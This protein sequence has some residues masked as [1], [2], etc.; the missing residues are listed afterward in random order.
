MSEKSQ[1]TAFVLSLLLGAL[2]IDRFYLG[3]TGL[4]L[5]KLFTCGGLGIWAIVDYVLIGVGSMKD[6]QGKPLVREKAV[7][8]P[9][10][11]QT[12]AFVLSWLLGFLGVDRFYLGYTG[13]GILKLLTIGG[14]GIWALVDLVLIGIGTM[15][16][17]KG[18][19]LQFT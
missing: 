5:L 9:E 19:S 10:K 8:T 6:I 14:L 16:D 15:K 2:G 18:N 13:L 12:T 4:G 7:G 1:S 17:A 11:S 3:Y